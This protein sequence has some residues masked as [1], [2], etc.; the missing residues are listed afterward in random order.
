[1]HRRLHAVFII[2]QLQKYLTGAAFCFLSGMRWE[3]SSASPKN[4]TGTEF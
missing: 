2:D 1:M 3:K 4:C